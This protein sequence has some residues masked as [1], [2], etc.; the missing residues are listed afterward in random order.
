MTITLRKHQDESVSGAELSWQRGNKNVLTV[1]PTGAGKTLVKSEVA[2]RELM[3]E[4]GV[5]VIFAHRDVLL[6]QISDALCML[7]L[8]HSFVASKPTVKQITNLNLEKWGQSFFDE[9]S[10]IMVASVDAF[11]AKLKK[12]QI[13]H[14]AQHCKLWMLDE[15]H[16]LLADN[17]WGQCVQALTNARGLGVTATPLR[18]DNMG[19]GRHCEGLFDDMIVGSS[20]DE[21]IKLGHLSPYKIYVPPTRL[22]TSGMR[23]TSSGDYNQKE[24]AKRTD[25]A[26]ITGDAVDHYLRIA[27]GMQA[28]TYCVNIA[29]SEHVAD[30]FNRAGVPSKALSSKTPIRER[31]KAIEDFKRGLIKNLVNSDLFGEGFDVPALEVGIMLRK[32]QSYSLFKQ[33]FGRPLRAKEG[34]PFGIIIDHVNNVRDMMVKYNLK[35]PHDD[36]EWTL[37]KPNGKRSNDSGEKIPLGRVCPECAIFYIPKGT[38][39][40]CPD[41]NHEETVDEENAAQRELQVVE[42]NLVEMQVDVM[43]ALIA[44]RNKVDMA[45]EALRNRMQ[46]APPV[47]RDSAVN[48]HV[49]RQYAQT[50]LRAEIQA[51]CEEISKVN[52]WDIKT[53]QNEFELDFGI[54]ILK[55]QT[56][57]ERKALELLEKIKNA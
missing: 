53:T 2:R 55:A 52:N 15:A 46:D 38:A 18:A 17:K 42:G 56:L 30:Q 34:K 26:E 7:N 25:K 27:N 44:E 5:T 39:N 13:N 31:Q 40:V 28:I 19:L 1:L 49:K 47:V 54:N 43:E 35:S 3:G 11:L 51:Y 41:C 20:M 36:P 57:S 14:L 48:N 32:T 29:H 22:D 21:L 9:R 50:L 8:T 4:R 16:H 10:T 33:Q 45:P 6:S 23:A 24:L 12:G 37:D